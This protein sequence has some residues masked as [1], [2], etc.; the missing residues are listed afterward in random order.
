MRIVSILGDGVEIA[1]DYYILFSNRD[2]GQEKKSSYEK[3]LL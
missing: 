3:T 1:S 2:K